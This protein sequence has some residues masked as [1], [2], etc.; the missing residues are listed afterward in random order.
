M[1]KLK[2]LSAVLFALILILTLPVPSLA[3]AAIDTTH[4]VSLTIR[5]QQDGTPV[6]GAPFALFLK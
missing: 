4:P 3:A 6:S 2:K 1:R 5:Y